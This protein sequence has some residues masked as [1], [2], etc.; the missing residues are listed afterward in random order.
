[1]KMTMKTTMMV[2]LALAAAVAAPRAAHAGGRHKK[3][4]LVTF[5]EGLTRAEREQAARDMGLKLT[6]DYAGLGISVLEAAGDVQPQEVSRARKHPKALAVEDDEFRKW[7]FEGAPALGEIEKAVHIQAAAAKALARRRPSPADPTSGDSPS[8]DS[9]IPWGVARVNAPAAWSS[10]QGEGVKVAVIDTGIDC[11]HPDLK[12]DFSAGTNIVD[13][14][15]TPM[16]DNEHGT[17]V[18]GTIA[19]RG[20]GGPLGVAPKATLIPVK[21]LDGSGSGSLSDIIAGINWATDAGVDVINMSLGGPNTSAALQRAVQK[22]LAAGVVIVCAAGNSGPG[23]NTVGYPAGYPG[24]I[25][26]AASDKNDQVAS[27][28]SRGS[29]VAFIAPGVK[30]TSTVPGGGVKDLSGTSMASPHVAGLAALAIERGAKGPTGVRRAFSS[31][32][33]ALSGP[34]ATEQ[35]AGMIDASQLR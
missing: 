6:D 18:S 17:H 23:P 20:T 35:G 22:A 2:A 5:E 28:S 32:A 4:L 30:I 14:G 26:V 34:A 21:V 24:V 3:R 31:A 25:A 8:S 9:N 19:G 33:T 1:M 12:C 27:F 29:A 11:T 10:G 13:P 15:A 7:I 16:D